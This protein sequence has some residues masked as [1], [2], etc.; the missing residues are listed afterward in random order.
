MIFTLY[1][2]GV[3]DA[4]IVDKG[5]FIHIRPPYSAFRLYCGLFVW[6]WLICFKYRKLICQT[7]RLT[8]MASIRVWFFA[9]LLSSFI[10]NAFN[11]FVW[12]HTKRGNHRFQM[13]PSVNSK[14]L[15]LP[16]RA[17][18]LANAMINF[19]WLTVRSNRTGMEIRV[20]GDTPAGILSGFPNVYYN[21]R[22]YGD[23]IDHVMN[24]TIHDHGCGEYVQN[25]LYFQPHRALA[26]RLF[27]LPA[28]TRQ[29]T[30]G[31]DDVVIHFRVLELHYFPHTDP[32]LYYPPYAYF[33]G[34][35]DQEQTAAK[36][37]V[38]IAVEPAQR[39]HVVVQQLIRAH[40]A[41]LLGASAEE[42]LHLAAAAPVFVGS[43]GTFS[44]IAAYLFR[45][46]RAHL[47]YVGNLN[48]GSIWTPQC[49]LFIH[50]DTRLRYHDLLNLAA[51]GLSAGELI[52]RG[53][54]GDSSAFGRCVATRGVDALCLP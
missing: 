46:R 32:H 54:S 38:W 7:F 23:L 15:I 30:F 5:Y 13:I 40:G 45:G 51:G 14:V 20:I 24:V 41:R 2:V 52:A 27:S 34:I 50:D 4:E 10:L 17:G 16:A 25:Y 43:Q 19:L 36:R 18:R 48:Q 37:N 9:L 1:K 44:W 21:P 28:G 47:P 33:V 6:F 26:A 35:L 8:K 22:E 53:T 49:D 29:Q 31:P 12:L 42:E 11:Q 39:A 3:L